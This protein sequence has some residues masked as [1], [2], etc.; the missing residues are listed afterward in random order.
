MDAV[1]LPFAAQARPHHA[2]SRA[3]PGRATPFPRPA[4]GCNSRGG[5]PFPRTNRELSESGAAAYSSPHRHFL[6]HTTT[7][8]PCQA[9]VRL[10]FARE[11]RGPSRSSPGRAGRRN[12]VPILYIS[13]RAKPPFVL[14][15]IKIHAILS[16]EQTTTF[17]RTIFGAMSLFLHFKKKYFA[18]ARAEKG[19]QASSPSN[20]RRSQ[21]IKIRCDSRQEELWQSSKSAPWATGR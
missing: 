8:A 15:S 17:C 18:L 2:R 11:P 3:H 5:L 10:P 6:N 4:P 19:R 12:A 1:P 16:F 9:N 21:C 20:N 14:T 13:R 7:P